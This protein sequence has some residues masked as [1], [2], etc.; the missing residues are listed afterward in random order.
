MKKKALSL[1][2]TGAMTLGTV[3]PVGAAVVEGNDTETLNVN[4]KVTGTVS[5]KQGT[6]P[7][8]KIQVE[9]P[10]TMSFAFDQAGNF[11]SGTFTI[12]N[13]SAVPVQVTVGSFRETINQ[14][15]ITL[16]AT[17]VSSQEMDAKDRSNAQ[18]ALQGNQNY[19]D[20]ANVNDTT[21]I[22]IIEANNT[23]N[24]KLLGRVGKAAQATGSTVDD[25]GVAEDFDLVFKI[26]KKA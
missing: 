20:L 11:T 26:K 6:A 16:N 7:A 2:I 18:L 14:G 10:T 9:V 21:V 4:V 13:K 5:N 1:L 24:I 23:D 3:L 19:V 25:K 12:Q 22:S 8:G 17:T 15:G